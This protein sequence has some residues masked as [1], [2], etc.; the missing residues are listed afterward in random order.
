MTNF[1]FRR[2]L[3]IA[4]KEVMHISRDP[5]TIIVALVIP[6]FLTI[7]FG[8]AIDL[9][10]HDVRL[11][12]FDDDISQT[13]RIVYQ[14]FTDSKYFQINE[15]SPLISRPDRP[16][17]SE[18][19]K[20]S[21]IIPY[22]FEQN[23]Y[24]GKGAVA[25]VLLDGSDNTTVNLVTGYVAGIEAALN[26]Q[27]LADMPLRQKINT[28]KIVPRFLFNPEQKSAWFIVPGLSV[29]ILAILSILLTALTIAREWETGSMEL[30]LST[31]ARPPEIILG[32]L[33]PYIF[34]GLV[35]L[36]FIYFSARL[37]FGVPFNGSYFAYIG[38]SLLFIGTYLSMGLF[39]SVVAKNQ[40][41][42]MQMSIMSGYM[43]SILLSGFI[44]SIDNMDRGWQLLTALLPARWYMT[45]CRACYLKGS[46]FTDLLVPFSALIIL[47]VFLFFAATK[48]FKGTL[49]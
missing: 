40:Q 49:E 21:L 27:F 18:H 11:A 15:I 33:L 31:P 10:I 7:M 36:L 25:Q 16:L 23:L 17:A 28:V 37:I 44:F 34:L 32:K 24:S 2:A 3:A 43:P 29:V 5:F 47:G 12:V 13:S 4:R 26:Q 19:S 6:V 38:A 20:V 14:K 35:A 46:S 30:L 48:R 9:D 39:I 8:F 22:Q 45:I 1:R 41:I 42:A